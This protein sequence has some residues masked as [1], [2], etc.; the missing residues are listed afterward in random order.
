MLTRHLDILC[1]QSQSQMKQKCQPPSDNGAGTFATRGFPVAGSVFR[2]VALR[3]KIVT[4]VVHHL[5]PRCC[6]VLH[7]RLF[8]VAAGIDFRQ[9][10]Q[11]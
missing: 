9:R 8:G 10:A 2:L 6:E 1:V 4:I 3:G 5:A 7:E 11:L